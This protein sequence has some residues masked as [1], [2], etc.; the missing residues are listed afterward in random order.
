M[1]NRIVLKAQDANIVKNEETKPGCRV[2][3]DGVDPA[4]F[5]AAALTAP[6]LTKEITDRLREQGWTAP[7]G[8]NPGTPLSG[9]PDD[10]GT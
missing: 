5:A 3:I 10:L 2:D 8:D 7:A 4:Q 9:A 6:A 1:S